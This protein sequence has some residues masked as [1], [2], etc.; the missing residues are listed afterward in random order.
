MSTLTG[1]R[2][3]EATDAE[4][5]ARIH[6]ACWREVYRFMPPEVLALRSVDYRLEQWRTWFDTAP[7]GEAVYVLLD[8]DAVVGFAMAKPN[9]DAAIDVPGEFHACYILPGNRG[10]DA[11]PVAMMALAQ[12][13]KRSGLWPA[14]VW[15]FKRN[16]YRR[17]Y[18]Q[19][20]CVAEVFRDRVI[21]GQALAEIGYRVPDYDALM[22]R[23]E[24]MCASA[25]R[26]QT[27]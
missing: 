19:L 27:G 10:G 5:I 11:G 1:I 15:A 25:V 18:P 13:L 12:H 4:T 7:A 23:L 22:S 3:A 21:G 9:R 16:P 2:P 20:G 17:I 26:R 8:G 14:C 6:A 24:T